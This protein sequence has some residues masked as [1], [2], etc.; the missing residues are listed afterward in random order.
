MEDLLIPGGV[1]GG[2]VVAY[3]AF[4]KAVVMPSVRETIRS[5]IEEAQENVVRKPEFEALSGWMSRVD[6]KL[7]RLLEK[8]A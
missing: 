5:M 7:D 3:I 6:K 1:A 8:D 4:H 2:A